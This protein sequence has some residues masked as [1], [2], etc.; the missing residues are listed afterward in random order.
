MKKFWLEYPVGEMSLETP[1]G[2]FLSIEAL[3]C[4]EMA[5]DE[6]PLCSTVDL[7][8]LKD[9]DEDPLEVVVAVPATKSKRGWDYKPEAIQ[10]V[11][12]EIMSNTAPGYLG[13]Q[14][15]ENI[16][17][18]FPNPVT[19]WVGAKW[20]PEAPIVDKKTNKVIGKGV[21][22]LR[23]VIDKSA[24]DLKRWIRGKVVTTTSIFGKPK[25]KKYRGKVDVVGYKLM[26]NDWTPQGRNGMPTQ[27]VA[28]GEMDGSNI[29]HDSLC[30]TFEEGL[31]GEIQAINIAETSKSAITVSSDASFEEIRDALYSA[32]K[33]KFGSEKTWINIRKTNTDHCVFRY[34]YENIDTHYQINYGIVDNTIQ[35]GEA[36]EMIRKEVFE[37]IGEMS[38]EID[39]SEDDEE[40][41]KEKVL[42]RTKNMLANGEMSISELMTAT[43]LNVQQVAGEM[44][45]EWFQAVTNSTTDSETLDKV[46]ETLGITGEMDVLEV[47]SEAQD[48]LNEKTENDHDTLVDK[49]IG[50]KVTGEMAQKMAKKILKVEIGATEEAISGEMDNLLKDKDFKSM[51]SRM[52][53]E[54][55]AGGIGGGDK[56]NRKAT[57]EKTSSF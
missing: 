10:D 42:E 33:E 22:Y 27:I 52:H 53:T 25:V 13:H 15:A 49:I 18:E 54:P 57:T 5:V 48:A 23:G 37:P 41:T 24:S 46:K 21:A 34:E 47:V 2:E 35:L 4:G 50:E 7:E 45:S 16:D 26:S 14:K 43:G 11:V 28:L 56:T 44:D 20:E 6:I 3:I 40:M 12:G 17:H 36:T 19:H 55:P 31:Q 39:E 1:Q 8:A 38:T 32:L 51:I 30:S 9:G 29:N